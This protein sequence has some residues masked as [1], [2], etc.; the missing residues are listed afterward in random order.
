MGSNYAN[1]PLWGV[2]GL[3]LLLAL[4]GPYLYLNT[5]LGDNRTKNRAQLAGGLPSATPVPRDAPTEQPSPTGTATALAVLTLT[6]TA[7]PPGSNFDG[8]YVSGMTWLEDGRTMV[9]I[10][11]PAGAA[12]NYRAEVET[13][14]SSEYVCVIPEDHEDRIYCIGPQLPR[15]ITAIIRVYHS[16][17]AEQLVFVSEFIAM[18]VLP[19]P[20][21]KA[22][23]GASGNVIA[24][25]TSTPTSTLT[26]TLT[27]SPSITP[28][29]TT[30]PT[31]F[32]TATPISISPTPTPTDSPT[33]SPSTTPI[34]TNTPIGSAPTE[35][36][37]PAER[38]PHTHIYGTHANGYSAGPDPYI[39]ST[40]HN[41]GGLQRT[42][43]SA[44][45]LH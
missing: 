25:S 34:L 21:P 26:P 3:T 10:I 35:T 24:T 1:R 19:T 23:S 42:G 17:S 22:T 9:R 8:A 41:S 12:G 38:D 14:R 20:S 30:T 11:V 33:P 6:P 32:H 29:H 2:V 44:V 31:G 15:G 18:E 16:A 36:P 28:T 13:N 40:Q 43:P 7:T 5:I 37:P 39:R 4:A 45:S 27:S